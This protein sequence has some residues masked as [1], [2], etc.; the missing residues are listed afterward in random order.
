[1]SAVLRWLPSLASNNN[2]VTLPYL[3][4][5]VPR[6]PP[7]FYLVAVEKNRDKSGPGDEARQLPHEKIVGCGNEVQ[8]RLGEEAVSVITWREN[9]L[10]QT[11]KLLV[12]QTVKLADLV[13]LWGPPVLVDSDWDNGTIRQH[14]S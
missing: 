14:H 4:S 6:P 11:P 8:G 3:A 2:H 9:S 10:G 1:M 13:H 5:L 7:R 12:N